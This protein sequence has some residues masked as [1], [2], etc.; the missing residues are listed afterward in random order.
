[1]ICFVYVDDCLFFAKDS[2]DINNVIKDL[3]RPEKKSHTSFLL[4]EENN[5]AGLLDI[6]FH[7]IRDKTGEI[8]EIR[9]LQ[10]GLIK[11]VLAA[12]GMEEYTSI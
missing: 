8:C 6:L 5:V 7:K 9:L 12:T 4:D 2:H 10:T 3:K 1:M 11:R